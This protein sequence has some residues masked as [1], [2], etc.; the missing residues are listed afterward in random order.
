MARHLLLWD[1]DK[2]RVAMGFDVNA[3]GVRPFVIAGDDDSH[4]DTIDRVEV[5]WFDGKETCVLSIDTSDSYILYKKGDTSL[6]DVDH[7]GSWDIKL[8][9]TNKWY[10]IEGAWYP[11]KG[12]DAA[13]AIVEKEGKNYHVKYSKDGVLRLSPVR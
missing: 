11:R 3:P 12:E 9:P 6:F 1:A 13:G 7:D 5:L 2:N 4:N 8:T 10:R